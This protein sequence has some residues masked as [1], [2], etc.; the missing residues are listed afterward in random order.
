MLL[1]FYNTFTQLKTTFI[2]SAMT[3]EREAIANIGLMRS[4][5][6]S[7]NFDRALR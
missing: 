1:L 6:T 5:I 3:R 7:D 2:G 4:L